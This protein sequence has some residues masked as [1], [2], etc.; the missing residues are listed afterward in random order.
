MP[1][2]KKCTANRSKSPPRQRSRRLTPAEVRK[3][4]EAS[5]SD[6]VS[7]LSDNDSYN[8]DYLETESGSD[9]EA[10]DD[11]APSTSREP[12]RH[13]SSTNSGSDAEPDDQRC[14]TWYSYL[15]SSYITR[16]QIQSTCTRT[17]T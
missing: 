13:Q 14:S 3:M 8:S 15:Y 16:V 6:S 12:A 2:R 17:C 5:D 1:K 7:E 9:E 10:D 4:I 11:V